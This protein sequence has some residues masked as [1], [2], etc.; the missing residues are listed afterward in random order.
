MDIASILTLSIG[1]ILFIIGLIIVYRNAGAITNK[2]GIIFSI[3]TIMSVLPLVLSATSD[4]LSRSLYSTGIPIYLFFF[5]GEIV[6]FAGVFWSW[7]R[8]LGRVSS[9]RILTESLG[10]SVEDS[11][12]KIDNMSIE[13]VQFNNSVNQ[14]NGNIDKRYR[15]LENITKTPV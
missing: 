10:T 5:I 12:Q 14:I 13:L 2:Y 15:E 11:S 6:V 3:A 8:L 4:S 9:L 7:L 1:I